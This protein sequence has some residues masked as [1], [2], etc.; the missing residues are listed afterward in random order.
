MKII[1]SMAMSL[2]GMIATIDGKEDFLSSG[3]WSSFTKKA[4]DIGCIIWG[5]KTYDEVIK[6]EGNHLDLLKDVTKIIV[7]HSQ[8]DLIE[9]FILAHSPEEAIKK[10]ESRG[11]KEAIITG[12]SHMNTEFAKRNLIDEVILDVNPI[13]IGEGIPIF[14]NSDFE[15]KLKYID[16]YKI[17]DDILEIKY[18]V[19]K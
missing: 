6:W 18:K 10:L 12:G 7:S 17:T 16:S 13:F 3:N 15:M 11:F 5:R 19:I 8:I 9:G 2:N 1:L 4:N 14:H